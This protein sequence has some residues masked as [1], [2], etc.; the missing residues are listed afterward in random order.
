MDE[1]NEN[2]MIPL[3]EITQFD[4]IEEIEEEEGTLDTKLL[5]GGD[6]NV[7]DIEVNEDEEIEEELTKIEKLINC[8]KCKPSTILRLIILFILGGV[9]VT[10]IIL[11]A[12]PNSPL[13]RWLVFVLDWV[14][15]INKFFGIIIVIIIYLI[16]TP[17]GFPVSIV[18]LA[19]GFL[20]NFWFGV[21]CS[22]IG[23]VLGM[24]LCYIMGRGLMR[25]WTEEKIK[26]RRIFQAIDL[27]V[28]KQAWKLIILTHLSP[29]LPATLLHYV[30]AAV[31]VNF[32]TFI[33]SSFVGIA[34][35][36]VVYTYVGTLSNSI[37]NAITGKSDSMTTEIIYLVLI[38][39]TSVL[40]VVLVTWIAKRE[41]K[42]ALN[43]LD[44]QEQNRTDNETLIVDDLDDS[45]VIDT[46]D[47][48]I[49]DL[50][51]NDNLDIND[52]DHDNFS[53]NLDIND[54]LDVNH[55][56]SDNLDINDLVINNDHNNISDNLGI[57]DNDKKEEYN[58][59]N[60]DEES[61][62]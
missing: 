40:L 46:I 56:I 6:G 49:D 39:V 62:F 34:P 50:N 24:A 8:L 1:F 12:L 11:G 51:I 33:I 29:I 17:F 31:G 13:I 19:S 23:T 58:D 26:Q 18:N 15:G 22:T 59:Q 42:K 52:N 41:L 44:Q 30:Y 43:E 3:N 53:D 10:V 61:N 27:A 45:N 47:I 14:E 21:L 2:I 20:F 35:G 4:D 55:N 60:D 7:E 5:I 37:L 16:V 54:N 32:L 9:I 28:Q 57:I 36:M 25:K 38:I 48:E